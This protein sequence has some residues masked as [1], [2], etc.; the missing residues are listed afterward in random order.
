MNTLKSVLTRGFN[1][2]A[3]YFNLIHVT[4]LTMLLL[5]PHF[6]RFS[7]ADTTFWSDVSQS[8]A[9]GFLE[10]YFA[11][12][13]PFCF[14]V[15]VAIMSINAGLRQSYVA[16]PAF[17]IFDLTSPILS[18][19]VSDC[20]QTFVAQNLLLRIKTLLNDGAHERSKLRLLPSFLIAELGVDKV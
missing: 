1:A 10:T 8:I 12:N 18:M 9:K 13:V 20:Y 7:L 16:S 4:I 17:C 6:T 19:Q 5:Q 14:A 3:V 11:L 15:A 2:Y